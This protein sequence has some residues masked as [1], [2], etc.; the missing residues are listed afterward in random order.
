MVFCAT[1]DQPVKP[2]PMAAQRTPNYS[3]SCF[4][5][6]HNE[7]SEYVEAGICHGDK[8]YTGD[9]SSHCRNGSSYMVTDICSSDTM[10]RICAG[11][12][13][14]YSHIYDGEGIVALYAKAR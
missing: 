13:V 14:L 9:S 6:I 12:L 8:V 4:V 10:Y 7:D 2:Q 11:M 5:K 1:F 3:Y